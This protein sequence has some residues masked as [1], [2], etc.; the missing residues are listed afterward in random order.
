M[1]S[2]GPNESCRGQIGQFHA[3]LGL[4][5]EILINSRWFRPRRAVEIHQNI[6]KQAQK[7]PHNGWDKRYKLFS[8]F[9]EFYRLVICSDR[10]A[11]VIPAIF[12]IAHFCLLFRTILHTSQNVAHFYTLFLTSNFEKNSENSEKKRVI[13]WKGAKIQKNGSVQIEKWREIVC[14]VRTGRKWREIV[15]NLITGL[16]RSMLTVCPLELFNYLWNKIGCASLNI[17]STVSVRT[18]TDDFEWR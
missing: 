6:M 13:V 12:V 14:I 9:C 5:Y 4:F 2:W 11:W 18:N 10:Q 7:C 17:A 1:G 8:I 3:F 15:C 16:S